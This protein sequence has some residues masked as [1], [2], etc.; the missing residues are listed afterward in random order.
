[1][2]PHAAVGTK[3]NKSARAARTFC[4]RGDASASGDFDAK[5]VL[6]KMNE[7]G[8]GRGNVPTISYGTAML[9]PDM[10]QTITP[11]SWRAYAVDSWGSK[12]HEESL[13][14]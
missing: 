10:L 8:I 3:K 2:K 1:M 7:F 4:T 11:T 12:G 6:E 9:G 14:I 5:I 13:P